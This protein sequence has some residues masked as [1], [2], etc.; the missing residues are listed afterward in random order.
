MIFSLSLVTLARGNSGGFL[1]KVEH[2]LKCGEVL[3]HLSMVCPRVG[4]V[5][6]SRGI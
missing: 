3:M 5:G 2:S 6:N 4:G 1:Q